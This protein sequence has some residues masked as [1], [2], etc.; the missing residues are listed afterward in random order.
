MKEPLTILYFKDQLYKLGG[1][2][3]VTID[4]LNGWVQYTK[5]NVHIVTTE[6]KNLPFSFDL[7]KRIKVH[8]LEVNFSRNQPLYSFLNLIKT[9]RYVFNLWRLIRQLKPNVIINVRNGPVNLFLPFIAG[10]SQ[11][12]NEYHTS[13]INWYQKRNSAKNSFREKLFFQLYEW[14]EK[15]YSKCVV[16]N[17]AELAYYSGDNFVIKPNPIFLPKYAK[18]SRQKA[19]IAAGGIIPRKG[20]DMLIESWAM[21]NAKHPDWE[22]K[23][24]GEGLPQLKEK[25][26][27]QIQKL[28]LEKSITFCGF[29]KDINE[30]YFKSSIHTLSSRQESFGMVIVETQACGLP[31]VAFDCPTGPGEI[32][33]DGVTGFLIKLGD[34]KGFAEK[35][36]YLIEHPEIREKMGKKARENAEQ[37]YSMPA[38][39]KQWETLFESVIKP[40][41]KV[42][43]H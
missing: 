27:N 31:T 30:E 23:I 25:L 3:K 21:V 14:A 28:N 19:V 26:T 5:H 22:L 34:I 20:Y 40:E 12:I 17:E 15:K 43:G 18:L 39:L 35:I 42:N 8:D 24:F 7:D 9:I 29:T 36:N 11:T 33:Q 38:V 37:K 13:G 4:K 2:E 10:K 32:I 16:L 6:Q 41:T 1:S